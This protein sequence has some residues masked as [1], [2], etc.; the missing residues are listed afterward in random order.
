[1][2]KHPNSLFHVMERM[3]FLV[4]NLKIKLVLVMF[5]QSLP[6]YEFQTLKGHVADG[7]FS[8]RGPTLWLP[9]WNMPFPQETWHN[10]DIIEL[11]LKKR[12]SENLG[13]VDLRNFGLWLKR[14]G[15]STY[16]PRKL[17]KDS[18]KLQISCILPFKGRKCYY[19]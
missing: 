7:L 18:F 16:L 17:T 6:Y 9:K 4:E 10:H 13:Q 14:Q 19:A 11:F 2:E 1:M 15:W 5:N 8:L 3:P 12:P